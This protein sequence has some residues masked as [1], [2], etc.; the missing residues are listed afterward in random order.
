MQYVSADEA[1]M[2]P[3][4][5]LLG[6]P[7]MSACA[8]VGREADIKRAS[9]TARAPL[10]PE[11]K[12]AHRNSLA[13]CSTYNL[14]QMRFRQFVLKKWFRRKLRPMTTCSPVEKQER[15]KTKR[16]PVSKRCRVFFGAS[17]YECVAKNLTSR[18]ACL[19]LPDTIRINQPF[20]LSFDGGRTIRRCTVIWRAANSLGIAWQS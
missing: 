4:L 12:G 3:V 6:S 1:R 7:A 5:A 20:E 13:E 16:T 10:V 2:S 9:S 14:F 15:R 19:D 18:G 8:A 17:A 11:C